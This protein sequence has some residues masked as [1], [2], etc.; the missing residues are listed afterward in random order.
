MYNLL[1]FII[2][3]LYS[4]KFISFLYRYFSIDNIIKH[5]YIYNLSFEDGSVDRN[6]MNFNS[7]DVL[8]CITTGGDNILN[9]LIDGVKKI[10]TADINIYQ[11][12]PIITV[13]TVGIESPTYYMLAYNST[14]DLD[15]LC[16]SYAN[17]RG[18]D[19]MHL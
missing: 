11:N 6:I 19:G 10:H 4:I 12:Q 5:T 13:N 16:R 14:T 1:F 18:R 9:Y 15:N 2:F 7:S 3:G 17:Q 8:L